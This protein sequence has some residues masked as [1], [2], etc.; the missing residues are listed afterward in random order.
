MALSPLRRMQQERLF[1]RHTNQAGA[2]QK[3]RRHFLVSARD[4]MMELTLKFMTKEISRWHL[5]SLVGGAQKL[6]RLKTE[7]LYVL[8][9]EAARVY[10][11]ME[12]NVRPRKMM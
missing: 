12:E 9:S 1:K 11:I 2:R 7:I 5:L 6:L 10:I 8:V 4:I 3:R